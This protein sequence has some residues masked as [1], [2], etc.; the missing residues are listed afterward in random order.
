MGSSTIAA[1]CHQLWERSSK[2]VWARAHNPYRAVRVSVWAINF[3][4]SL[5]TQPLSTPQERLG[6]LMSCILIQNT[7]QTC[8][9][10]SFMLALTRL[11]CHD[12][13]PRAQTSTFW[14]GKLFDHDNYCST[15]ER[16]NRPIVHWFHR[17]CSV[18]ILLFWRCDLVT[19]FPVITRLYG[20]LCAQAC[21]YFKRHSQDST[22]LKSIVSIKFSIKTL[23]KSNV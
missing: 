12:G 4:S 15:G 14:Q 6:R 22:R 20:V 21:L 8:I 2:C 9:T 7:R 16:S 10:I 3:Y 19:E 23:P 11:I 13:S 1:S 17:L 5:G 18:R